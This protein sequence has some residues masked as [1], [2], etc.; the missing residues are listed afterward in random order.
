M[1]QFS[2]QSPAQ[3]P[4]HDILNE[5][6]NHFINDIKDLHSFLFVNKIWSSN[7]VTILWNRPFHLLLHNNI[8]L[9]HQIIS[10]YLSCLDKEERS[11]LVNNDLSLSFSSHPPSY[12]Y[13]SF[14]RHLSYFSFVASIQE[15]CIVHNNCNVCSLLKIIQALFRLFSKSSPSLETLIFGMDLNIP[16]VSQDF[17]IT[18]HS[19]FTTIRI[20]HESI[21]L[22][23]ISHIKE[24]ELAGDFVIDKSFP[25]LLNICK[26]LKK[27]NIN[28]SFITFLYHSFIY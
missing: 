16:N 20:L 21:V 27:V 18:I 28:L 10:T 24:I 25:V 7:V 19:P 12:N 17:N 22:N 4:P 1:A 23:W 13:S 14:L 11:K 8:N 3:S 5:I 26:D 9:S 15:W 6:F 2:A